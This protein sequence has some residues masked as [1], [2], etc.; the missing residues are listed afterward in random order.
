ML[1]RITPTP[2]NVRVTGHGSGHPLR[3]LG[4]WVIIRNASYRRNTPAMIKKY[5]GGE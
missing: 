3:G 4:R 1:R 2:R 5:L